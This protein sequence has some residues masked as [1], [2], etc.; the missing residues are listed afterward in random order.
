VVNPFNCA[1]GSYYG[2]RDLNMNLKFISKKGTF[3]KTMALKDGVQVAT[4]YFL[5]KCIEFEK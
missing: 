3:V 5:K 1:L 2:T 4:I